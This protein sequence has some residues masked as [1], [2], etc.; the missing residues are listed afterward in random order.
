MWTASEN[1]DLRR[2]IEYDGRNLNSG[3]VYALI[4]QQG[5]I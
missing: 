1:S 2:L 5:R 4:S 3:L